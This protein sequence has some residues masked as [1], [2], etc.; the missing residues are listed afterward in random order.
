MK[1]Q[2][3]ANPQFEFDL[4]GRSKCQTTK[5]RPVFAILNVGKRL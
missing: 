1:K 4:N 2:E 3:F 5:L